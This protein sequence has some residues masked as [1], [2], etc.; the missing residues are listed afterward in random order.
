MLAQ[1][2][3]YTTARQYTSNAEQKSIVM[4]WNDTSSSAYRQ[5]QADHIAQAAS[6]MAGVNS[7]EAISAAGQVTNGK[8]VVGAAQKGRQPQE[9]TV[10]VDNKSTM[11]VFSFPKNTKRSIPRI[12]SSSQK[13]MVADPNDRQYQR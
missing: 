8:L 9:P 5:K 11:P 13:Q 10:N 7:Q 1:S 2:V 4:T 12:I 6:D 3:S